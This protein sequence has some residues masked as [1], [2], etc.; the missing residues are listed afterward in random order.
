MAL[1][2]RSRRSIRPVASLVG[3][4]L[5]GMVIMAGIAALLVNIQERK[6][7]ASQFPLEVVP[8]ADNEL[9]PAVWG[10]NFPREY[11]SFMKTQDDTIRTPY[12][13]SVPYSKL[14][15]Y[16]AMVRIYAGYAF[17]VDYNH[18]RGHYYALIDQ[19]KTKRQQFVKQPA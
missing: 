14:A 1:P 18:A 3:I 12:G 13:G 16:P 19:I 8:I 4:F 7:E 17:S 10:K 9:N 6:S 15:L 5:M 2:T 11:D